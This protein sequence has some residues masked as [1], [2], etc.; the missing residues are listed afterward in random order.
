M[1]AHSSILAWRIPGT[2]WG[3]KESD[4]TATF[5]SLVLKFFSH[6]L[7]LEELKL[8]S[9]LDARTSVPALETQSHISIWG[10]TYLDI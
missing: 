9:P 3:H 7:L 6:I 1:A 4:M 2:V 10:W 8:G 5:T